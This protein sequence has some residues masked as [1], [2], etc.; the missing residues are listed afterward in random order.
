M[1]STR[2]ARRLLNLRGHWLKMPVP[3]LAWHLTVKSLRREQQQPA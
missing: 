2:F 1:A 3:L